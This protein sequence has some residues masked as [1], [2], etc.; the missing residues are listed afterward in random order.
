M[1]GLAF[2]VTFAAIGKS[3]WPRAT[4]ERAGGRDQ[5]SIRQTLRRAQGERRVACH[6][7]PR[8]SPGQAL[9]LSLRG[10]GD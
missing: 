5:T 7:L 8:P 4:V 2:L 1:Q 9:T 6:P 10:K 3:D